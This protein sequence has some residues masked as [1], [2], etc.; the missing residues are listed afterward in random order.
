M[1]K[2]QQTI[3]MLRGMW[4]MGGDADTFYEL[5]AVSTILDTSAFDGIVTYYFDAGIESSGGTTTVE[6]YNHTDSVPVANSQIVTSN[7][8]TLIPERFRSG[9]IMLSG[10]KRYTVRI[11]NSEDCGNIILFA[12]RI[13]VKQQGIITK[14]QIHQELGFENIIS[15]SAPPNSMPDTMHFLYEASKYDGNVTIRHEAV[16]YT[17]ANQTTHSSIWDMTINTEVSNSDISAYS[18]THTTYYVQSNPITLVDGHVYQPTGYTSNGSGLFF[19]SNKLVF[20]IT[21]FTKFLAYVLVLG[22]DISVRGSSFFDGGYNQLVGTSDM[23]GCHVNYYFEALLRCD[24][25]TVE[26]A[27]ITT[28]VDHESAMANLILESQVLLHGTTAYARVRS[29]KFYIAPGTY[30]YNIALDSDTPG[31][32]VHCSNAYIIMEVSNIGRDGDFMPILS[33]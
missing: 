2:I 12:A 19:E 6:L 28:T 26:A 17:N 10:N 8:D 29:A 22:S 31:E 33:S 3:D 24:T 30:N 9:A 21:N 5:D 18:T 14:T 15:E 4:S 7:V 27:C 11:K 20:T 16:L 1:A 25:T 32:Y 13:I 23:Q